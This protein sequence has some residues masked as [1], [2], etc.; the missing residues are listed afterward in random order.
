MK[1]KISLYVEEELYNKLKEGAENEKRSLNTFILLMIEWMYEHPK[2][3]G[4]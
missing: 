2:D 1:K 3:S 4:L